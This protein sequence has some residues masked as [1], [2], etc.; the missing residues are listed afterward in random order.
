MKIHSLYLSEANAQSRACKHFFM[1]W[2]PKDGNP[3]QLNGAFYVS[4]TIMRFVVASSAKAKLGVLY[5][6]CQTGIIFWLTLAKMGHPQPRTP[7]NCNNATA[8]GIA[9]NTI[10]QQQ[11]QSMKMRFFWVGETLHKKF[12]HYSGTQG[13][14]TL[15]ITKASTM[16]V[17]IMQQ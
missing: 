4:T 2:M 16:L 6:N 1:G 13:K 9:N 17:C 8:V 7:D 11:L 10:K 15:P 5:H 3:I 12:M 14:K